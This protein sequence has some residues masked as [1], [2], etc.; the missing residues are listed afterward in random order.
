M[1]VNG[2]RGRWWFEP[3]NR[4]AVSCRV[5]DFI[6]DIGVACHPFRWKNRKTTFLFLSSRD[7]TRVPARR[8][9]AIDSLLSRDCERSRASETRRIGGAAL[10]NGRGEPWAV[11]SDEEGGISSVN[12]MES[13]PRCAVLPYSAAANKY[14]D[15][16]GLG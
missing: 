9:V 5:K 15:R 11:E 1:T 7:R 16:G 2:K 12:R 10:A 13:D 14:S 4:R 3:S 6:I 8:D